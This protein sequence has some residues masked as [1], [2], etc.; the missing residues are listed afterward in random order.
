MTWNIQKLLVW[1]TQYLKNT[2]PPFPTARL[3]V[4]LLLA[5]TL[6]CA[7]IKL[8]TDYDRPLSK[9]ELASFKALFVRRL[10]QEPIAY[11]LGEKDFMGMTFKVNPSVLIPRQETELLV[12][13]ATAHLK[14]LPSLEGKGPRLLEVGTGSGCIAIALAKAF[15]LAELEAWDISQQS[16]DLAQENAEA[17][18]ISPQ[19]LR[20]LYCDALAEES[21]LPLKAYDV[22]LSNPPYIALS[23]SASLSPSVLFEPKHALFAENEGLLFYERFARSASQVLKENGRMFLEIGSTQA[24]KVSSLLQERGWTILNIYKD[25]SSHDRIVE[26]TF[27]D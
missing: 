12:E 4:E 13:R 25:Y 9:G 15:P 23:E 3:D 16:L 7:R 2:E 14:S 8:Y 18:G 27:H 17:Q 5:H 24:G 22:F 10:K 21:W 26:C 19:H 6:S 1:G 11:I 20:F